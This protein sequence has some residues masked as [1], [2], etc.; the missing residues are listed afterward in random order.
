[1]I[2]EN[3]SV[4]S[5]ALAFVDTVAAPDPETFVLT[6]KSAFTPM[7]HKFAMIPIITSKTPYQNNK[8]YATTLMGTG[9]FK[10]VEYIR[11]DHIT[12]E[13]NPEYFVQGR[14]FVDRLVPLGARERHTH[15]QFAQWHHPIVVGCA[16]QSTR[17]FEADQCQRGRAGKQ[18]DALLRL[19]D[20]E[21]RPAD[22]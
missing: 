16:S 3:Q 4:W 12:L 22:G 1:M 8:T 2:R 20:A 15:H 9:P 6:L 14:A 5:A 13:K 7:M 21:G 11:G 18:R 10:F 17:A 19:S